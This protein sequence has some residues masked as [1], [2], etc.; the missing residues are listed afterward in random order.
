MSELFD[1]VNLAIQAR[2][3]DLRVAMPGIIMEYDTKTHHASV[4]PAIKRKLSNRKETFKY[5]VLS[6][7][8]VIHPRSAT[9]IIKVP[10]KVGDS[11][12]LVFCDRGLR[13]WITSDG[14]YKD[15]SDNR[16]HSI[17]DAFAIPGGYPELKLFP[18]ANPDALEIQVKPGTKITIGNDQN[19]LIAM[20]HTAFTQLSSL[21]AQLSST[22]T[23]IALITH[24]DPQ[25]GVTG[26]PLN[27]INFVNLGAS[28][29]NIK[30]EVDTVLTNIGTIKV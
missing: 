27:V 1:F 24:S 19:D 20:A 5:P 9:A 6:H 23:N 16:M 17:N 22:L 21:C 12:L 25:G 18:T 13:N 3:S 28:V 29:N 7:V 10:I 14:D 11:V 26:P 8:P 2:E 15:P 4:Q 30:A